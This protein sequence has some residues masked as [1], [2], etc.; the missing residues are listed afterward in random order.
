MLA[1]GLGLEVM[2][3][4]LQVEKDTRKLT[5]ISRHHLELVNRT[6]LVDGILQPDKTLKVNK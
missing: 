5:S 6:K 4:L 1:L 2:I 3:L